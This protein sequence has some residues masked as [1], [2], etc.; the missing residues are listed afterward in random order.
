MQSLLPSTDPI[1]IPYEQALLNDSSPSLVQAWCDYLAFKQRQLIQSSASSSSSASNQKT[2]SKAI[3]DE[4]EILTD[5]PIPSSVH[6]IISAL[7]ERAL[8]SLPNS[9]KLWSSYLNFLL[10]II[11]NNHYNLDHPI[12]KYVN[13]QF[14]RALLTMSRMPVIWSLYFKHLQQQGNLKSLRNCY[15][16]AL[17]CLP[18]TQHKQWIWQDYLRFIDENKFVIPQRLALSVWAR[19]LQVEPLAKEELFDY[20]KATKL[21]NRAVH[22]LLECIDDEKF[23]SQRGKNKFE[24]WQEV[25]AICTK[26]ANQLNK[27]N[28]SEDKES[29]KSQ[30]LDV[31]S[32]IRSAISR[33]PN[34]NGY[35]YSSLANY[36]IRV[37]NF[38]SARSI[39]EESLVKINT[40]KDF[41]LIF[42]QYSKMEES[43][44]SL[45]M[46][47][48]ETTSEN[49]EN[50]EIDVLLQRLEDLL[51]RRP[52]LLNAVLLR[53]NPQNVA[54]WLHRVELYKN[55]EI[56]QIKTFTAAITA[57]EP[58]KAAGKY[59][60]LWINFAKLYEQ[61]N[62]L[63]NCRKIFEKAVK[64]N[65]KAVDQ[66]ISV[67]SEWLEVE[68]K[69][70]H[71]SFA[72]STL[73]KALNSSNSN[74]SVAPE[75]SSPQQK[76]HKSIKLW[77]LLAD[78]E[79]NFGSFA[80]AKSVYEQILALRIAT[81]QLIL[82]YAGFLREK[83]YFEESFR[84]F[85]RG[86]A[87]FQFPH[88]L[89]LWLA[90][91]REFLARYGGKKLERA[92]VL[93]ESALQQIPPQES[94]KIYLFYAKFEENHGV[95]RRAMAI[96]E[97]ACN[98]TA[99]SDRYELYLVW[100][101][102]CTALL[103]L[104]K[105][106]EIYELA[107]KKLPDA[108]IPR[109]SIKFAA[110]ETKLGEIDRARV[111]YVYAGQFS[112][113]RIDFYNFWALW[114]DFEVDYGSQESYKEM[115]RVKRAVTAKFNAQG[116]VTVQQ[117]ILKQQQ[118]AEEKSSLFYQ[119]AQSGVKRK[120]QEDAEKAKKGE[121]KGEEEA[122]EEE[123]R[124]KEAR[125]LE[126]LANPDE[127]E[128][129]FDEE[130]SKHNNNNST[131]S[132]SSKQ[133]G[134][135]DRFKQRGLFE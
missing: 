89:P 45:H 121:E 16:R 12:Y 28:H 113:P 99:L 115:L 2:K 93:F 101:A 123:S 5:S 134:A 48:A 57:V 26:H 44:I 124:G 55:D 107:L 122:E 40:V 75:G 118:K 25:I 68:L 114:S 49:S 96:Y 32:I 108:H 58:Q 80:A 8:I 37:G 52:L 42:D 78:L 129:D 17:N 102:R 98:S 63:E 130:E 60:N 94:R 126:D 83:S 111:I 69:H 97:R 77:C 128:I 71:Y 85:E 61:Q 20:L 15:N 79:E 19:Y 104:L 91:L 82:S 21:Y 54:D 81:P 74:R 119:I 84:V 31:E 106:R 70:K 87:F 38:E 109:I 30:A 131:A 14:D 66:L 100:I 43:L 4:L 51:Q 41:Q 117:E 92:R 116:T 120:R 10:K 67:Y 90:Y 132:A 72:L 39:Y 53:Q 13:N 11:E 22:L 64:V 50:A 56:Q 125:G 65:Y 18:I 135:L 110:M 105:T 86:I 127:I 76:L 46:A 35:F 36:Y 29:Q 1:D 59:Q 34:E 7:Y 103:G 23:I 27:T 112:D 6:L 62:Q 3:V 9:Y 24:L 73:K 33:Y 95:H 88:I 133:L 47:E